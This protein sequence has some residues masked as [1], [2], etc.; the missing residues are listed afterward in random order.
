MQ[1]YGL[2]DD[3]VARQPAGHAGSPDEAPADVVDM[4]RTMSRFILGKEP[5]M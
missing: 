5:T 1:L 2:G 4:I 3:G